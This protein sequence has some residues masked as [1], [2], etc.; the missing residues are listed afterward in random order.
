MSSDYQLFYSLDASAA[1]G[2]LGFAGYSADW[3]DDP[4]VSDECNLLYECDSFQRSH[5]AGRLGCALPAAWAHASSWTR[6]VPATTSPRAP[7]SNGRH[8]NDW[9]RLSQSR[10]PSHI[11]GSHDG[12]RDPDAHSELHRQLYNGRLPSRLE[13]NDSISGRNCSFFFSSRRRHTSLTCDWSSD[14][15][16]S[17]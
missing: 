5:R 16:S 1:W 3:N 10:N 13:T 4:D 9:P 8:R 15:C 12:P 17:D 2:K 7:D 6:T 14:V 11:G